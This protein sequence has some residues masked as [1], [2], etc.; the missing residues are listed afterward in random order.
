MTANELL[1]YK[2][3]SMAVD[4]Q[5]SIVQRIENE[6]VQEID[7]LNESHNRLDSF[8]VQILE[9]IRKREYNKFQELNKFQNKLH[10]IVEVDNES[11]F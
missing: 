6:I 10:Q 2:L 7:A 1:T 3:N 11:E 8:V 5:V 4:G 9:C